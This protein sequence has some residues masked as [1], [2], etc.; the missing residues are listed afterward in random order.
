MRVGE[1]VGAFA[2]VASLGA[3][4][5]G[6]WRPLLKLGNRVDPRPLEVP[7]RLGAAY[8]NSG[9]HQPLHHRPS[10]ATSATAL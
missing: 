6:R 7:R 9:R 4:R 10:G 3:G 5:V 1:I 8:S 2:V